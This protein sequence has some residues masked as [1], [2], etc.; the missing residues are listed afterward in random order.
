VDN[1]LWGAKPAKEYTTGDDLAWEDPLVFS[2][3]EVIEEPDRCGFRLVR[4]VYEAFG[5]Y[6]DA[7]PKEFDRK[8]GRLVLPE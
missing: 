3:Q 5:F 2:L 1:L 8:T 6:E 7:I 4:R